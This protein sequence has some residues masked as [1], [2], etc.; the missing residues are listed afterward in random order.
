MAPV[1]NDVIPT[2]FSSSQYYTLFKFHCH[3]FNNLEVT[4][5]RDS[6]KPRLD[7]VHHILIFVVPVT[8]YFLLKLF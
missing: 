4:R 5:F 7:R 3:S 6:K 1:Q 8:D 2:L